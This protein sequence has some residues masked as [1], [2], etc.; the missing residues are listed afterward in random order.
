M[1]KWWF[2]NRIFIEFALWE[3]SVIFENHNPTKLQPLI[4]FIL[5]LAFITF[6][7]VVTFLKD[8]HECWAFVCIV[9]AWNLKIFINAHQFWNIIWSSE[10]L[11]IMWWEEIL[12]WIAFLIL[13]ARHCFNI[14][15]SQKVFIPV[16]IGRIPDLALYLNLADLRRHLIVRLAIFIIAY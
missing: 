16:L 1:N 7:G 4:N 2:V 12:K 14:L 10:R 3:L 8:N 6:N 13:W 5:I 9:W 15:E 11:A